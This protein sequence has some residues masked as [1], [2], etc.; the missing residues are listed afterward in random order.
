MHRAFKKLGKIRE[1]VSRLFD[2]SVQRVIIHNCYVG[3]RYNKLIQNG[4]DSN[5]KN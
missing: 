4:N 1:K 5:E 2:H 3:Q